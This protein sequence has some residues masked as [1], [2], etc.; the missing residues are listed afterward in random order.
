MRFYF[1]IFGFFISFKVHGTVA[2]D[3]TKSATRKLLCSLSS[4]FTNSKNWKGV[5]FNSLSVALDVDF[6]RAKI[7]EKSNLLFTAKT[8]LGFTKF[9]DSIWNKHADKV[10]CNYVWKNK[11]DY[12][13]F[14]YI[15]IHDTTF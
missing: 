5:S 3:T 8:E 9:I 13:L 6:N 1:L 15:V 7:N 14:L 2:D 10:N 4:S 11:K 12:R